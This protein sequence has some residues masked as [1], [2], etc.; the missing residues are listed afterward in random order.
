M[1]GEIFFS[2]CIDSPY[3]RHASKL[4]SR[5]NIPKKKGIALTY[6]NGVHGWLVNNATLARGERV[7]NRAR[8]NVLCGHDAL[9]KRHVLDAE[10][11]LL[12]FFLRGDLPLVLIRVDRSERIGAHAKMCATGGRHCSGKPAVFNR[13]AESVEGVVERAR[14][15]TR[16]RMVTHGKDDNKATFKSERETGEKGA[17][18]CAP[19]LHSKKRRGNRSKAEEKARKE[20]KIF[21]RHAARSVRSAPK[22]QS[23]SVRSLFFFL[24]PGHVFNQIHKPPTAR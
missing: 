2:L 9:A 8:R 22:Q 20:W 15:A 5:R 19:C 3:K 4:H 17:C 21:S 18:A 24:T 16:A 1:N 6:L 10:P 23:S 14:A 13:T 11:L 7:D 12:L